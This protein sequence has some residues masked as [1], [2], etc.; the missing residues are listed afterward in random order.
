MPLFSATVTITGVGGWTG[1]PDRT[2][3][4]AEQSAASRALEFITP[5]SG[6]KRTP[7][8]DRPEGESASVELD[9]VRGL[10]SLANI[11]PR[12]SSV[13]EG[14]SH[15]DSEEYQH[16][17]KAIAGEYDSSQTRR[18]LSLGRQ[19]G[20]I[21]HPQAS[22][23]EW[24]RDPKVPHYEVDPDSL[25]LLLDKITFL[26]GLVDGPKE[27]DCKII[28]KLKTISRQRV[29][30]RRPGKF[31][32]D[33][34]NEY[35]EK[36][37]GSSVGERAINDDFVLLSEDTE[38]D[39]KSKLDSPRN[40]NMLYLH[41]ELANSMLERLEDGHR[42][43]SLII[44]CLL[45]ICTNEEWKDIDGIRSQAIAV[46]PLA[47]NRDIRQICRVLEKASLVEQ[48]TVGLSTF[49]KPTKSGTEFVKVFDLLAKSEW[50]CK[51][52]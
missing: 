19:A 45:F 29:Q 37:E 11:I 7:A 40:R 22:P 51:D 38:A 2:K 41:K 31:V 9:I 39:R 12:K 26:E 3:R 15:I 21:Y 30:S 35:S 25:K 32:E 46:N 52:Y 36:V 33:T 28:E 34:S 50:D 5:K 42:A 16:R 13:D 18:V 4:G 27:E 17:I 14:P 10:Y 8:E 24:S 43:E 23:F 48:D 20:V 1:D 49:C 47:R 44:L 6:P